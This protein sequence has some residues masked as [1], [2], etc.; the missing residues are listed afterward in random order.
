MPPSERMTCARALIRCLELEGVEYVFG[1]PGGAI[2]PVYDALLHSKLVRHILVRH[3]QAGSHMAEGYARA[4]GRVGVCMATSGPGATNL[5]TGIA[6]AYM[7]S[8]PMVAITG[9]VPRD[10]IGSDAF[11]E[12]DI[13]GITMPITKHNWLVTNPADVPRTI[14]EAFFV[15]RSGRPGPVLVDI[16][17]DVQQTEIDF[18]YPESVALSGYHPVIRGQRKRIEEAARL[19]RASS[20]PILYLGGGVHWSDAYP[21]VL[22]FV[23]RTGAPA[24]T[25]VHGKGALPETHSNCLGMFGLHGARYANYTIQ[26]SDLIVAIG[27]RFDD[28]VTGKLS[29]FAPEAK[30]IHLDID[31]AE[32]SKNVFALVPIVGDI[33]AT[34][35]LLTAE[36]DKLYGSEG[37]AD[38]SAWWRQIGEWKEAHPLR[39]HQDPA[40]PILPQNVVDTIYRKTR[41]QAIVTTGVGEHQMFAAQYY[42]TTRP[43]QFI[44]SGGLGT[45]GYCL[46]A[47]IGAQL[48]CPDALVVG[49]DGD[50][51]FQMTLQDLATAVK[52]KLPIKHFILNNLYLGMVRQLQELFYGERYSE[53]L[54]GDCP[55]FVK[56]AD[57]YGCLGLRATTVA[58]LDG[59]IDQ[60]LAHTG[61]PVLVDIRVKEDESCYPMVKPG[62]ALDVM[63]GGE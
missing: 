45:M 30:V 50:G 61:G 24:V 58:E 3:E 9:N 1:H 25:T 56:L 23:T 22:A 36:V 5:V 40:G 4:T 13:T 63:I 48:G 10:M 44:T 14:K 55:D 57:A 62:A 19:I 34:L 15:A 16:P 7:D 60:A 2:L 38:L 37:P 53:V 35:P 51:S 28:R 42:K 17:K 11:Q 31:P 12:A 21:E 47:S 26:R 59:V 49:I 20:R 6:D 43:R 33:K 29:A 46:P 52:L 32:I 39:Y 8:T 54:L 41:G 27:A 18:V